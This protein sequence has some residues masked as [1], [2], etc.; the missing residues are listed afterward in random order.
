MSLSRVKWAERKL[1]RMEGRRIQYLY[2]TLR[3]EVDPRI[4]GLNQDIV[5]SMD[6]PGVSRAR[7]QYRVACAEW[8][9][10]HARPKNAKR[11]SR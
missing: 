8:A 2:R 11:K 6:S 7:A 1:K 9:A 10:R 3:R 4:G 5:R